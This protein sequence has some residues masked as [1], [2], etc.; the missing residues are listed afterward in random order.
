MP[1]SSC[2]ETKIF[3]R[4]LCGGCY[5]RL[6]RNGSVVRKN[7][8]NNGM[9]CAVEDCGKDAI[10]KGLCHIHY[11]RQVHPL[12]Q[13][14]KNIR[15]RHPGEFPKRWERFEAFI[16]DVGEKPSRRHQL[17]RIDESR[18]YSASNVRWN[19]P[20]SSIDYYSKDERKTYV[21]DWR[22]Q[23]QYGLSR[24]DYDAL[25]ASQNSAC[26]ICEEVVMMHVDHCHS[27]GVVRGLLCIRCNRGLGYFKDTPKFL[28]RA[29]AYLASSQK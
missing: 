7:A 10:A 28:T 5:H 19:N 4:G 27:T 11:D 22:L 16:S 6:R 17:R 15:T 18:P 25:V 20:V 3:A 14:W 24:A 29:A 9:K 2:N 1:C 13:L 21:R 26:A 23:R 12:K 8:Q